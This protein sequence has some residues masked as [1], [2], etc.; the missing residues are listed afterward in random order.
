[1][2]YTREEVEQ[3]IKE[4]DYDYFYE[5]YNESYSTKDE[6]KVVYEANYGDGNEYVVAMEFSKLDCVV[7]LEGTYSS[8]DSPSWDLVAFAQPYE[9]KEIRY[10]EATLQYMRDKTITSILDE[11]K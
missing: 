10:K 1:M 7:L 9:F 6:V 3:K 5:I 4:S 11:T 8:W 2:K